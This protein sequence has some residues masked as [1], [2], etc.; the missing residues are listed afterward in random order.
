MGG[1]AGWWCS[2]PE[3]FERLG[4]DGA[5]TLKQT[6][7]TLHRHSVDIAE[8]I[9][10][11]ATEVIPQAQLQFLAPAAWAASTLHADAG[12]RAE[13]PA[14][15]IVIGRPGRDIAVD[16]AHEHVFGYT[17]IGGI[18]TD[19]P[20]AASGEWLELAGRHGAVPIG[21]WVVIADE[22]ADPR[23]LH[24]RGASRGEPPLRA[25]TQETVIDVNEIVS[26]LSRARTLEAGDRIVTAVQSRA[27]M[28]G[29]RAP[30]FAAGVTGSAPAHHPKLAV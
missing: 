20:Q 14:L 26:A 4:L 19:T 12:A 29:R 10:S 18:S 5:A 15:A 28:P 21:P 1:D 30:A 27:R 8:L 13:Q 23:T 11:A 22:I 6:I 24:V 9:A 7:A 3:V 2:V 17:V 16:G 25:P